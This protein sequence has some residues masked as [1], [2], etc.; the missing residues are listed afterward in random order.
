ML[1]TIEI[2][3]L[4]GLYQFYLLPKSVGLLTIGALALPKP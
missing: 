3:L 1:Q 2:L 4:Q